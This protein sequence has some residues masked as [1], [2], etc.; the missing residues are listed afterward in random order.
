MQTPLATAIGFVYALCGLILLGLLALFALKLRNISAEKQA[1]RCQEK[2]RD[3]FVYL[4]AY[5]EEEE[6][7]KLPYGEPT[8]KEKQLIQKQLFELME[9]FTGVHREKLIRLCEDMGLVALDLERLKSGWKWT[10]V[11]A[12]YNLGVMRSQQAAADL[13]ALLQKNSANDP[14][15]FI[16]A[17]AIAKCA[18]D[19]SDLRQ[20]A[21]FVVRAKKN[22]HQLIVD[23]ISD[24]QLDTNSLYTELIR[25]ND[26]ELVKIGLIGYSVHAQTGLEPTL[27]K[28]VMSPDKEVR[29]KA[30]KLMCRDVRYLSEQTVKDFLSH[31][32]WEIR[33]LI[34]KAIGTLQL[35]DY[36]PAL[37][38]AVGDSHWWVRHHS[39]RSLAQLH[40]AG[41]AALCE[42]LREERFGD[43]VDMAHQIILDDLEKEKLRLEQGASTEQQ[44]A[45]NEKLHLY[46]KS[47][48]KNISTVQVMEG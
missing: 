39:A 14:S 22:V 15:L 1:R 25:D 38:K 28:L 47:C 4:Q 33:A 43:K 30:V 9:R 23:I 27:P 29:I 45:Y 5:S 8:Q 18:R 3:Y 48:Q 24:S 20:M 37:K 10:R 35:V 36:I 12:A 42:I 19:N 11:D 7:L 31:K 21:E 17:R 41:F 2:Y 44:L 34:A 46:R 32:D 26:P 13:L 6:R 40:T 16:V